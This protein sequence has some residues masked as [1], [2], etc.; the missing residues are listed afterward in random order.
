[1]P[2]GNIKQHDLPYECL[3]L[4]ATDGYFHT[5][6]IGSGAMNG[7]FPC[8]FICLAVVSVFFVE[9]GSVVVRD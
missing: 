2:R 3:G 9:D 8:E 7:H 5:E 6:F 4:G 1:M